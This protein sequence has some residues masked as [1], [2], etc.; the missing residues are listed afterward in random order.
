MI[1]LKYYDRCLNYFIKRGLTLVSSV[2]LTLLLVGAFLYSQNY[3]QP[4][5]KYYTHVALKLNL[6]DA[7]TPIYVFN[8]SD[9]RYTLVE[10]DFST[11][12]EHITIDKPMLPFYISG[13][14]HT[15]AETEG[16]EPTVVF[17]E[18]EQPAYQ[19][20]TNATDTT[21]SVAVGRR[22]KVESTDPRVL[23][24]INAFN[25]LIESTPKCATLPNGANYCI[26]I[27]TYTNESH[28]KN[29]IH[30]ETSTVNIIRKYEEANQFPY[31]SLIVSALIES[32]L[33]TVTGNRRGGHCNKFGYCHWFQFGE[34]AWAEY[35]EGSFW[36]NVI[37]ND[38]HMRATVRLKSDYARLTGVNYKV[39]S[40][41]DLYRP[42]Q[43]GPVGS[44]LI[45]DVVYKRMNK[46]HDSVIFHNMANNVPKLVKDGI[47]QP[48]K[49][50][51]KKNKKC[52]VPVPGKTS[53]DLAIAW[54]IYW[55]ANVVGHMARALPVLLE[56][57]GI[58]F[59]YY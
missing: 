19:I 48:D 44:K 23:A 35:G 37:D 24:T 42:H 3:I 57:D 5:S 52:W 25:R 20:T 54:D 32:R 22:L 41:Y 17:V 4:I 31:G 53:T 9:N 16:V 18:Q 29:L 2:A 36:P 12:E 30:K 59:S 34:S 50:K 21:E 47:V 1:F 56:Q 49:V 40:P 38:K 13:E 7:P 14:E 33:G 51:C 15:T 58:Q 43:Q 11:K 55:K 39:A 10:P 28:P 8:P 27:V 26:P 45:T 6:P 46:K